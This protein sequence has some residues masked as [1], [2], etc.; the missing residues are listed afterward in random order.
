MLMTLAVLLAVAGPMAAQRKPKQGPERGQILLIARM[1][2]ALTMGLNKGLPQGSAASSATFDSPKVPSVATSVTASW[3]LARG[4]SQIVTWSQV[5][6]SAVPAIIALVIPLGIHRYGETF[7]DSPLGSGLATSV[8]NRKLEILNITDAN[9]VAASTVSLA[10][11]LQSIPA[12]ELT[13]DA[14]PGTMKIQVQAI[15]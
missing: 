11:P 8:S 15:P 9:R 14:Y 12:A 5:K 2:E 10:D 7:T 4:R 13:G 3:A 6:R 1:P